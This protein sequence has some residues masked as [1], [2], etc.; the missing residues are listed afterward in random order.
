MHSYTAGFNFAQIDIHPK[1]KVSQPGDVYEQEADRVAEQ[2]M[3]TSTPDWNPIVATAK[4]QSIGR[5]CSVCEM[6]DQKSKLDIKRKPLTVSDPDLSNEISHTKLSDGIPLNPNT[7]EFMESRFGHDFSK[8]RIHTAEAA[9][10]TAESI[11]ARAYT[12]GNNIFFGEGQYRPHTRIGRWLLSHELAHVVQQYGGNSAAPLTPSATHISR[13]VVTSE[14]TEPKGHIDQVD[15]I[16]ADRLRLFDVRVWGD[17]YVAILDRTRNPWSE[18]YTPQALTAAGFAAVVQYMAESPPTVSHI[19][20]IYDEMRRDPVKSITFPTKLGPAAVDPQYITRIDRDL[21]STA[22]S[23][24]GIELSEQGRRLETEAQFG[25][26][27]MQLLVE[28]AQNFGSV[29]QHLN[30]SVTLRKAKLTA[31]H[32]F[33][34]LTDQTLRRSAA[35][36]AK[37]HTAIRELEDV[38]MRKWTALSRDWTALKPAEWARVLA[39]IAAT[40]VSAAGR[41]ALERRERQQRHWL[42][43]QL[44]PYQLGVSLA[45]SIRYILETYDPDS[46]VT[47]DFLG[48]VEIK[49][50]QIITN[51][52]QQKLFILRAGS[53]IIYQNLNDFRFYEQSAQGVQQEL[54]YGVYALVAEK[55]KYIIPMTHLLF[56]VAAAIFPPA[57]IPILATHVLTVTHNFMAREDELLSLA[58]NFLISLRAFDELLPG[59][60]SKAMWATAKGGLGELFFAVRPTVTAKT[61]L[62]LALRIASAAARGFA[63]A[64]YKMI[65]DVAEVVWIHVRHELKTIGSRI[66][67]AKVLTDRKLSDPKSSVERLTRELLRFV[68]KEGPHYARLLINMA[69]FQPAQ[70]ERL[71]WEIEQLVTNG[72]ALVNLIGEVLAW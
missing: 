66:L 72:N 5:I 25:A 27:L 41:A 42:N 61:I 68:G 23:R 53:Q 29:R 21:V 31:D 40:V 12:I 52:K 48:P 32:V 13:Q 22:I 67:L 71:I 9:A 6:K 26:F 47:V 4:E 63:R 51:A 24:L 56:D 8:V 59:L 54:V 58:E 34:M 28:V 17:R 38:R 39:D 60:L 62:L 30:T 69:I 10:R 3:S 15:E 1:W 20:A 2:V 16:L 19:I 36:L 64:K 70:I 18:R 45:G 7:K 14:K 37:S 33:T 55:T 46:S 50:G 65:E 35:E 11:N 49:G 57:R 44:R 43:E